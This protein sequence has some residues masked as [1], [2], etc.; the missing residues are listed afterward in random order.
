MS[1]VYWARPD[2]SFVLLLKGLYLGVSA[3][4]FFGFQ[5]SLIFLGSPCRTFLPGP[6]PDFC[7]LFWFFPLLAC[8]GFLWGVRVFLPVIRAAGIG[9]GSFPI[10]LYQD[11]SSQQ[12]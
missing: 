12:M 4:F 10:F 3:S 6:E 8:G 2:I 11:F 9:R 7:S 1:I 5:Y